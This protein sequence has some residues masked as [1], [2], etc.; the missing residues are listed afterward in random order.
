[1]VRN[2]SKI[3]PG[4]IYSVCARN[5][6]KYRKAAGMSVEQLAE[7]VGISPEYLRRIEA[8]KR[9]G[10]FTIQTAYDISVALD[11]PFKLFFENERGC[12]EINYLI[13]QQP[14]LLINCSPI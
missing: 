11:I 7:K 2:V 8:P 13:S 1:M 3:V 4:D 10:G 6:K 5:I 12:W 14:L 9:K